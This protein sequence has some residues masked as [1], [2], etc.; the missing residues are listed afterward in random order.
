MSRLTNMPRW[1]K[2]TLAALLLV[3]A[4]AAPLISAPV[5]STASQIAHGALAVAPRPQC[6]G[7]PIGC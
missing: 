4:L 7:A 3:G 6:P 2:R 1:M 5:H